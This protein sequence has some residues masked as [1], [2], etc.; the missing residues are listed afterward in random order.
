MFCMLNEK[1]TVALGEMSERPSYDSR[2]FFISLE[3]IC[4]WFLYLPCIP[5]YLREYLH[6]VL[7]KNMFISG[8][9]FQT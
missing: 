7:P 8:I 9:K 1:K 6:F 4:A 5:W 2:E 3:I